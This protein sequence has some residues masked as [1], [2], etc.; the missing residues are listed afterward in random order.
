MMNGNDP[1][2]PVRTFL[3]DA[4]VRPEF[5]ARVLARIEDQHD[6]LDESFLWAP[7]GSLVAE[8]VEEAED[9]AAWLALIATRLDYDASGSFADRRARALLTAATQHAGEADAMLLE[10]RRLVERVA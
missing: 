8:S 2:G 5:A 9:L 10:L 1:Y 3:A 6:E 7:L 4:N